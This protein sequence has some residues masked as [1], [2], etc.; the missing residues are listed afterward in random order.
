MPHGRVDKK[1]NVFKIIGR[2]TWLPS[3]RQKKPGEKG[4]RVSDTNDITECSFRPRLLA[5]CKNS[6]TN[7]T[8]EQAGLIRADSCYSWPQP[9]S[10]HHDFLLENV[11]RIEL[12]SIMSRHSGLLS[13]LRDYV[14][15]ADA[16][17]GTYVPCFDIPSL[18]DCRTLTGFIAGLEKKGLSRPGGPTLYF[19]P[20][21]REHLWP[22]PL[23]WSARQTGGM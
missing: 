5:P 17:H 6:A 15:F 14:Y 21:R 18:R 1:V 13:S 4:A 7:H 20:R 10:S 12:N 23:E 22:M 8:N 19:G 16:K 2:L 3:P 11:S 9:K